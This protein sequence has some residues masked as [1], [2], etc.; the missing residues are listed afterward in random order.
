MPG[1]TRELDGIRY[2]DITIGTGEEMAPRRCVYTHYTGW[3]ADG[4]KFDSSRDPMGNGVAREPVAF[5]QG[6]KHVIDGWDVG[7]TGMRV[8]GTRRLFVPYQLGY[9]ENGNP[10]S[11]PRKA[12]LVFEVE[13][14]A[15]APPI[16][17]DEAFASRSAPECPS[18]RTVKAR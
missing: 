17:R 7:F 3:L 8:G 15:I 11:I 6:A 18:W 4:T 13:L 12:D 16:R 2:Q 14:V 10:P 5:P 9:G 1:D